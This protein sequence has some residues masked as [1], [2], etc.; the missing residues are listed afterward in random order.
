MANLTDDAETKF[1]QLLMENLDWLLI[2]DAGGLLGSVAPGSF[3]ISLHTADPTDTGST[4]AEAA[5]TGY[6]R[7]AVT[8]GSG[9]WTTSGD[10]CDNDAA[11]L[12]AES[13]SGPETE[14]HIGVHTASSGAGNMIIH[15]ALTAS[16]IVN[17]GIA[18]NIPAGDLDVI[19]A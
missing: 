10:T 9:S 13:S 7:K 3:W 11:I 16:L 14:T 18:P 19:A 17:P 4:A 5:Y 15:G 12:F 6:V 2:G 8:R 1:L